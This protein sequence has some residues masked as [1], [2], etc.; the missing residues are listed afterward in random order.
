MEAECV[1]VVTCACPWASRAFPSPCCVTLPVKH[2]LS[3]GDFTPTLSVEHLT[4][5]AVPNTRAGLRNMCFC[6]RNHLWPDT[7][8]ASCGHLE[9]ATAS[10]LPV[11]HQRGSHFSRSSPVFGVFSLQSFWWVWGH[12]TCWVEFAYYLVTWCTSCEMPVQ[13]FSCLLGCSGGQL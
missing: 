8:T 10:N 11:T 13:V 2:Q 6:V 5:I 9:S 12:V 7:D 4:T 3:P 1:H